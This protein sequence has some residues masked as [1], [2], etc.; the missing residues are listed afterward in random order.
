MYD[1][2][3]LNIFLRNRERFV[4]ELEKFR[5]KKKMMTQ[6]MYWPKLPKV[7]LEQ[8]IADGVKYYTEKYGQKATAITLHQIDEPGLA[9]KIG[10]KVY[11]AGYIAPDIIWIGVDNASKDRTVQ[12]V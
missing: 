8:N 6:G 10:L 9:E 3:N 11:E 12:E 1:Q 2:R 7:S 5:R 4:V